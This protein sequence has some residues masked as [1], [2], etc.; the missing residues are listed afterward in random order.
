MDAGQIRRVVLDILKSIAPE[1]DASSIKP[2]RPLRQQLDLDSMDCLNVVAGLHDRLHVDIPESDY[3]NLASLDAIVAYAAARTPEAGG[4][5][6]AC[7]AHGYPAELMR[8]HRMLDG[9]EVT[10]RPIRPEDEGLEAD[11]MRHLSS[12]S[13]YK[14]FMTAVSELPEGKLKYL[15]DVDYVNHMALVATVVRE[16]KEIEVGVADYVTE[17]PGTGCEFAIAVDDAWQGSGLAGVL[18][19]DLISAA[20]AR[21]LTDM[22]GFILATNQRMLKFARQLGFRAVHDPDDRRTVHVVRKL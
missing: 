3:G 1:F 12:E 2:D 16:G 8:R 4:A 13:R 19:A 10:V 20:R 9:S 21:G 22:E 17:P 15:T 6:S 7:I 14:R 18:M 11:F 5:A